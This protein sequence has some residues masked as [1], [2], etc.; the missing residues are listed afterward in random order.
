VPNRCQ[1]RPIRGSEPP[2]TQTLIGGPSTR[3]PAV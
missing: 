1:R 3:A 2:Q